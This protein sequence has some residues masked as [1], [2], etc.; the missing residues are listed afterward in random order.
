MARLVNYGSLGDFPGLEEVADKVIQATWNAPV[1]ADAYRARVQH[2]V[3]RVVADQ[4]MAQASMEGNPAEVRAIL[5]DRLDRLATMIEGR[6]EASPHAKLVAGDVRRWQS[7]TSG[8][9]PGPKLQMPAGDPIGGSPR[10]GGS[11]R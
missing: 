6:S 9:M 8:L 10:G 5:A 7:R 2:I 4:M 3:Q 11:P 1:P